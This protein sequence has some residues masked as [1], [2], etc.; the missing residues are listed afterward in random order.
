METASAPAD[1]KYSPS[2][3]WARPDEAGAVRIGITHVA[4]AILGD[5]VHLEMPAE[6]VAVFA[7]EPV[8][9]IESSYVVF[10]VV[11]P[12]SG[13]VIE[14]N[15]AVADFPELATSDPYGAGWLLRLRLSD[16]AELDALDSV[17]GYLPG[18]A[19]GD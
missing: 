4:A 15:P 17:E 16:R 6:G 10:E 3:S 2:H 8:G 19:P 11:S 7:G 12:V 9:L 13:A 5:A 1:R 14:V 18:A